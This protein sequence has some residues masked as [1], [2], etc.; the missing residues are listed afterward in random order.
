MAQKQQNQTDF[1]NKDE[2]RLLFLVNEQAHHNWMSGKPLVEGNQGYAKTHPEDWARLTNA[3]EKM[4]KAMGN[5]PIK[6]S[7]CPGG[8]CG[9]HGE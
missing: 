1:T 7:R 9:C 8:A 4:N 6:S 3:Y 2:F 5:P